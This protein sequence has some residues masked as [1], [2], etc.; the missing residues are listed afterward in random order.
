MVK[1]FPIDYMHQVCLGVMKRLLVCWTSGP[2]QFKLSHAQK[3]EVN[4]RLTDFRYCVTK[5]FSRKPR[6][7][8]EPA[9]CKATECRSFLLYFGY[10][11]LRKMVRDDIFE[12]FMCLSTAINILVSEN[13]SVDMA[14]RKF[15]HELLLHIVSKSADTCGCEV[16]VYNVH[17]L[18]HISAEVEQFGKLDNSSAFIFENFM[19]KLKRSVRSARNPVVQLGR[20]QAERRLH[21][22]AKHTAVNIG[23]SFDSYSC[24][25]PD[26]CCILEDGRCCQII[27]IFRDQVACM[28]FSN[29]EPLFVIPCDSRVLGFHKVKLSKG[30][31]KILPV[32]T[33]A[34]KSLCFPD[35]ERDHLVFSKLL[36]A[37]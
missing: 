27:N 12:H 4:K 37:A 22:I 17:S 9:H 36:H 23:F 14:Y 30:V 29:A 28:V 34:F 33:I 21:G 25:A 7:L 1:F 2:K 18:V 15:A 35:Y 31:M 16:L 20:C 32:K 5:E 6:S 24:K 13:L 3:T 26:N 8:A 19:Q 10:F 11:V